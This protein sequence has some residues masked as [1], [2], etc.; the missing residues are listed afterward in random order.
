MF[1]EEG[2]RA[3]KERHLLTRMIADPFSDE[4]LEI[5]YNEVRR[6][7]LNTPE[8]QLQNSRYIDLVLYP[9]IL[10][11]IYQCFFQLESKS[12]AEARLSNNMGSLIPDAESSKD[13]DIFL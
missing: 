7:W 6:I 10:I 3:V 12:E 5:S 2:N 8:E 1:F 13:S 9:E 4:Q 11:I